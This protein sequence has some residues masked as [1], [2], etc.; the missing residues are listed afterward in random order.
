MKTDHFVLICR[1]L[2]K[3]PEATQ[4]ELAA[5]GK[6]SL[7]V[8]NA[9][10]KTC[11]SSG[12]L[13][14]SNPRKLTVT[15]KGK[16]ELEKYRVKN[17]IILAAGFGFRYTPLTYETPKGLL[18]VHGQPMIERQIEQLIEKEITEIIIVVG[19]KKERFDYLIDKYCVK[20]VYN[21]EYASKNNFVSLYNAKDYLGSTY[22][23]M[24]DSWINNNIFN[25]YESQSW[26]SCLYFKGDT[27]EW[28]VKAT[29][30]GKIESISTGGKDS[31]AIVGPAFLSPSF[32]G[33]YK[34]YLSDYYNRPGT[35]DYCWESILK[36]QINTLPIYINE[37]TG[38]V[39]E[40]ENLDELMKF[41]PT[42]TEISNKE[43]MVSIS[44][45]YNVPEHKI[46]EIYPIKEG[47]TNSTFHFSVGEDKYTY[48]IAGPG[49]DKLIN[50]KNE[51]T[52]YNA[53][54]NTKIS[55]D[56]ML[57]CTKSGVK[58]SKFIEKTRHADPNDD[59]EL[60][61]CMDK[62][63]FIHELGI[64]CP[65][66][67]G[68][69]KMID[70]YTTLSENLNAIY[71]TDIEEI[72]QKVQRLLDI[73]QNLNIPEVLC[74]GDYV[75]TN[76]LILPDASVKVI[77]W[78]HS[79]MGDPI[80]DVAMFAIFAQFD[81]PRIDALLGMYLQNEPSRE[82]RLRLYLYIALSG[83]LWCM[84]SQYKQAIG[85]EFGEYPLKMY[86]YMKDYYN[87]VMEY[88]N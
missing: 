4:R 47:M 43:I 27:T 66:R 3:K 83:F 13:M 5:S 50:R 25:T 53:I 73:T 63:R 87:I 58:I 2:V 80:M 15:E 64:T 30:S 34:Q 54:R 51:K 68:I 86:R 35:D 56:V 57:L 70:Y 18:E 44:A 74:H 42:Y 32:T 60:Q 29:P 41:D 10:I 22:L 9:T 23:L 75:H 20:L 82:E 12:Y 72:K 11:L 67:Y 1:E 85:E 8:V 61:I 28:C 79:G 48:R 14:Q 65:H 26:F 76:I 71:F 52:I 17:A 6:V 36:E 55:D 49:I 45:H 77:D 84:W 81:K 59:T 78:E 19:Y 7:G 24:S 21:P 33:T 46:F 37:Q 16:A 62:L 31:L 40:F 88:V 39:H 38:N 69:D